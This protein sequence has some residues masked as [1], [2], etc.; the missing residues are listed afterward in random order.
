MLFSATTLLALAAT[1]FAHPTVDTRDAA[2]TVHLTFHGGPAEYSMTF[3]ADGVVRKTNNNMAVSIIDAPDYFAQSHCTFVTDT[4]VTFQGAI[5]STG[6]QQILVGP[7]QPIRSVSC[8]GVCLPTYGD[9]YV[10]GQFA[11]ICCSG[12]CAANKCRPWV[13]PF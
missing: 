2:Q 3:P 13:S 5:S 12:F 7:P 10:N 9:C 8:Q 6:V 4:G 1:A 11:G